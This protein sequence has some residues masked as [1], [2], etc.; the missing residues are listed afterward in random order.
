MPIKKF[1]LL[2]LCYDQFEYFSSKGYDDKVLL[3]LFINYFDKESCGKDK[4]NL[5]TNNNT[6]NYNNPPFKRTQVHFKN[7]LSKNNIRC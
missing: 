6:T 7:I 4:Q 5:G 3:F 2:L 1:R